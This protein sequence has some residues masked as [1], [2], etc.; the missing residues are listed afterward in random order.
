MNTRTSAKKPETSTNDEGG[1]SGA[2]EPIGVDDME[3]IVAKAIEAALRVIREEVNAKFQHLNDYIAELEARIE[4]LEGA[5]QAR[6]DNDLAEQSTALSNQQL[7]LTLEAIKEENR[8]TRCAANDT[9]QYGRRHNLRFRGLKLKNNENCRN[10]V[11]GFINSN[12]KVTIREEDIEVA[13][14]LPVRPAIS[15]T[16]TGTVPEPIIIARFRDRNIRDAVIRQRKELK[17]TRCTIVEDLT[18]LNVEVMNRLRN[19]DQVDKC[20]SWNGHIY[21]LLKNKKKIR[22]RPYQTIPE[23]EVVQ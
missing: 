18:S 16:T 13:H 14:Q 1:V 17:G 10:V 11:C 15:P 4:N 23:C 12:L 22:V 19:S 2:V 6:D 3:N 20:W 5:K 9:E 7:Q 21:A 8:R